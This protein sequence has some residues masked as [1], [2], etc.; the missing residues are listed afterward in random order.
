M[1][2]NT[3]L[4]DRNTPGHWLLY[5]KASQS[6]HDA[7]RANI[8]R[9]QL[10]HLDLGPLESAIRQALGIERAIAR[11][12]RTHGVE[13]YSRRRQDRLADG[14]KVCAQITQI[15]SDLVDR[16]QLAIGDE[17]LKSDD[18]QALTPGQRYQRLS[19]VGAIMA[20]DGA[21]ALKEHVLKVFSCA[22]PTEGT[23]VAAR[24][25]ASSRGRRGPKS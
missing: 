15:C 9:Q 23:A 14:R 24:H 25:L 8:A 5:E 21:Y 12:E 16:L 4:I 20:S 10:Q 11:S 17:H 6:A 22:R 13:A 2:H 19:Y 7:A 1:N 3:G 18:M